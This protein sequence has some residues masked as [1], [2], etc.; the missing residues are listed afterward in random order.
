LTF[1]KGN[2]KGRNR[3]AKKEGGIHEIR[4]RGGLFGSQ[5]HDPSTFGKGGGGGKGEGS[6]SKA[7]GIG[8]GGLD[9]KQMGNRPADAMRRQYPTSESCNQAM[10][11]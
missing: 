5:S 3:G 4:R 9:Y 10:V 7:G 6:G 11:N 8:G 1:G 2:G